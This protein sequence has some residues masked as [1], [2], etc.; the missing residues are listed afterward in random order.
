ML[1]TSLEQSNFSELTQ[2]KLEQHIQQLPPDITDEQMIAAVLLSEPSVED[3]AVL[4]RQTKTG[5]QEFVAYVTLSEPFSAQRLQA[6]LQSVLPANLLPSA[7]VPLSTI[8]LTATGQID[9][10]SLTQFTITDAELIQRWETKL[11]SFPE[12]AQAAVVVQELT[13]VV[14]PLHLSDLLPN[15]KPA[16]VAEPEE[17]TVTPDE[18][19]EVD[20]KP[21]AISQ[22]LALP[23]YELLTLQAVLQQTAQQATDERIT[24][25]LPDGSQLT[26]SYR[27]LLEDAERILAG[28]RQQ[29]LQPQDKIIFQLELNQDILP[30]FWGCILGGFVPVI[31]GVP[32]TYRDSNSGVDKLCNV[33]KLLDQPLILTSAALQ[34]SVQHLSQW[35][36]EVKVSAIESLRNHFPD[37]QHHPSHPDDTAFFNLTSGSTGMPKCI[38]LTHRNLLSRAR[39]TNLLN[40][41]DRDDVILNWLPYDHIGSISDWHI[42]C[43]ELGCHIVCATKEYVLGRPLNWLD[44]IDRYR[45]THS[46][47]PN[48][49][50]ALVN[51]ALKQESQ[52]QWDLSCVKSLLTAGEAVSS[53]AVEDFIANLA[54]YGFKKTAIRPAFGMAEMGSGITYYQPTETEP[55][56][57]HIVDKRSLKGR[58]RRVDVDHPNSA[59]FTDLGPV[60]PG[61][62]IRIVDDQNV[63]VPEDTIGYL[64]VKGEAVF[65]GYYNNP[66][67]NDGIFTADGWFN[68]GDLGFLANGHLVVTG[69]AKETIIINGANYYNHEIEAVVEELEGVEVSYTAACAVRDTSNATEQL[70]IFFSTT[71]KDEALVELLKKIRQTVVNKIGLNP[72]FLLPVAQSAIPKTA[73]GKIQRSQLSKQFHAGEFD[74]VLRQVDILLANTNTLPDWFYRKVWQR[75]EI[76]PFVLRPT[77]ANTLIFV[78]SLGL[79]KELYDALAPN[80]PF[81]IRVEAGT[82]FTKLGETHY[83]IDPK[84]ADDYQQLLQSLAADQISI[85]QVLHLWSY[86]AYEGVITGPEMLEAALDRGTYSVLFLIQALQSVQPDVPVRLLV[87]SSYAQAVSTTDQTAA[88]RSPVLG[89]LKA[90]PQEMPWLDCRHVDLTTDQLEHNA[91]FILKE[92]QVVQAEREVAYRNEQRLV[93][94]LEKVDWSHTPKPLPF[95]QDGMY[96]LSGGLGGI[97]VEIAKYLLQNYNARLLLVGR[98][99]L[100][101]RSTWDDVANGSIAAQRIAAYRSLEQ[102]S[103]NIHYE[104]VDIGDYIQL[105]TIVGQVKAQWQC[106]LDGVIHLAGNAPERLL[107]DET[108]DSLAATLHP[109]V[110]GTWALDQLLY[111]QPGAVFISFSSLASFF[112]GAMIGAYASANTFLDSFSHYQQHHGSLQSYCF[113]WAMWDGIGMSQDSSAKEILRA[114]GYQAVTLKQGMAS[115]LTGLHHNQTQLLVGLEGSNRNIQRYTNV[116]SQ[117]QTLTAYFTTKPN[118]QLDAHLNVQLT[119]QSKQWQILDRFETPS[120]CRFQQLQEM[121]LQDNGE[122][123]REQLIA[124]GRR[125]ATAQVKPRTELEQQLAQLW[126]QILGVPQVGVQDSFFELGGSSLQAARLF[127]EIERVFGRNLP[128][129]TLFEAQTVEQIAKILGDEQESSLW[130]SVVPIQPN[131]SKPPLFCIHGAGGNVLLYRRL[132]DYLGS[133]QP[134]Y[135]VQPQ[136]LNSNETPIDR[137]QEM[138]TLYV[139]KIRELQPEGPYYLAGLSVGGV[140]AFEMANIL[141]TQGQKVAFLGLIDALGPGY[142]K[143]LPVIPRL[144]AL[145]PHVAALLPEKIDR[146]Q[147]QW[148]RRSQAT[149]SAIQADERPPESEP[150]QDK[151]RI[152]AKTDSNANSTKQRRSL[153]DRLETFSLWLYKFTP[154]AFVIP[155][156]YLETGKSLPSSSLQKVQEANVKALLTYQ[157]Q[158]YSGHAVVFRAS[159]QPAGCYPDPTLGWSKFITGG[160]EIY[161]VPGYHGEWLLYK[162]QSVQVLGQQLQTCLIQAQQAQPSHSED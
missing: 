122:I 121:P 64:Q 80:I 27:A 85:A 95:K 139:Q 99:P 7:Y 56:T 23:A 155:R 12:I 154:W 109:K 20:D 100:P 144:L 146:L 36:P 123:D 70:A 107:V 51:D 89:L 87:A 86:A 76:A 132:V 138:A 105:Q 49:A 73:I 46:W 9:E 50:Y 83:Q 111:N 140:I 53:K 127:A 16:P 103:E 31:M 69:R 124:L 91:D 78:D 24:Y 33:W 43:V 39:G 66:A 148:Q 161:D 94:R 92:L 41:H 59:V 65:S 32:A 128:L 6:Y 81:C 115:L 42:R 48:F 2:Q 108:R 141:Q 93:P 55:L 74:A 71:W 135:G 67:A 162:P 130:S 129:A 22:G 75:K 45:I 54:I 98:T 112:G 106:D 10:R 119:E 82:T 125:S 28:L 35:L 88:E 97:G 118:P 102:L 116:L 19:V 47:A 153:M 117:S 79:G 18:T 143:L 37:S 134:L 4:A 77:V 157:P 152:E 151:E 158:V 14:P 136:G 62:E 126:Q 150:I 34:S 120:R 68:T 63:V 44:L 58:L 61:V 8:P 137:L 72:D 110:L 25:L 156:F 57:R 17:R 1:N 60:I 147:K 84:N 40:Q 101:E 149:N 3:C 90:A 26:Q 21:P 30:A 104:A 145:A 113:A 160:L 38:S 15:W 114:K 142:P 96:L 13:E 11:Q 29:G 131:G 5:E 133:D 159:K 52:Q